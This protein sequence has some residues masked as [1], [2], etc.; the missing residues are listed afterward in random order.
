[1]NKQTWEEYLDKHNTEFNH[2]IN[3]E[4]HHL[5]NYIELL[6][7]I[8]AYL[9]SYFEE[10]KLTP[11]DATVYTDIIEIIN[12]LSNYLSVMRI[13]TYKI[14]DKIKDLELLTGTDTYIF[15]SNLDA[16]TSKYIETFK[17]SKELISVKS[18]EL[19]VY[20]KIF[21]SYKANYELGIMKTK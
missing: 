19:S 5:I 21:K 11:N 15:N 13:Y 18:D 8:T 12:N 17:T 10:I 14:E 7:N 3:I 4:E 2:S 1:M 6:D 9:T 16:D 20:F